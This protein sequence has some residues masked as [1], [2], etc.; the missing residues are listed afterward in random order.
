M[1]NDQAARASRDSVNLKTPRAKPAVFRIV[2]ADDDREAL[3][4][5]G[6]ILRGPTMEVREATSGAEL[7]VLL[8]EQ[9]PFD[10]IVTDI[11]MPWMDGL[12]VMR[13]ARVAEIGVPV[14]FVSG[15]ARPEVTATVER[16]GNA[17]ILR[18]P[19]AVS[20]LRTTVSGMLGGVA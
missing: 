12:A 4:L 14:L 2:I 3:E 1:A 19:I 13:S 9:G 10:L 17:K 7:A 15:F 6:D 8:A 16:L 20:T 18:K 5:L 11:D